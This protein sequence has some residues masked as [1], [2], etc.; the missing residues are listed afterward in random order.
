MDGD[1]KGGSGSTK[2]AVKPEE[3]F[4]YC[5]PQDRCNGT[6]QERLFKP[7]VCEL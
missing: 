4:V 5:Y 2:G 7:H 3:K 6:S 1:S